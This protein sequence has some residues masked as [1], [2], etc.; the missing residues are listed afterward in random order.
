MTR[1]MLAF[2]ILVMAGCMPALTIPQPPEPSSTKI[3]EYQFDRDTQK[4]TKRE[5]TMN[6]KIASEP[7]EMETVCYK[8]TITGLPPGVK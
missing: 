7:T 4:W 3:V 8:E 6:M 2:S 5:C 1:Y